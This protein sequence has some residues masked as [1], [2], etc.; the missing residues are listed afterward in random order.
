MNI[1]PRLKNKIIGLYNLSKYGATV[2][3]C[4]A[5]QGR[6][7]TLLQKHGLSIEDIL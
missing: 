4:E 5:A 2:G 1:D 7:D 3:E 6:L